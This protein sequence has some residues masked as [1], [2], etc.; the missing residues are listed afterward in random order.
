MQ[1]AAFD[2]LKDEAL[3]ALKKSIRTNGFLP[4]DR[5]IVQSYPHAE[6]TYVVV[7][8]NRRVA[9]MRWLKEDVASG[10]LEEDEPVVTDIECIPVLEIADE[11][12][13][14]RFRAKLMGIRH[15][16]GIREWGGYQRAKLV[17]ALRDE[18][19]LEAGE[20]ADQLG[21]SATEVNRRYRAYN[22]LQQM[23]EHEDYAEFA[24][25]DMYPLFH[26]A[27]SLPVVREWVGWDE[28]NWCFEDTERLEQL[29]GLFTPQED[30]NRVTTDP[31]I[32]KFSEVRELR[33][34]LPNVE[35]RRLLFDDGRTFFDA[36]RV[37]KREEI[38]EELMTE[39]ASVTQTIRNAGIVQL[40]GLEEGQVDIIR[41]LVS[42][43]EE[44]L[45]VLAKLGSA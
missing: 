17:A 12:D 45:D 28:E 41:D 43:A 3:I 13:A 30:D 38:S 34:I 8:G 35:A 20:I 33:S 21:M 26:E 7:E 18:H 2:R 44:V 42:A 40:K 39:V 32:T 24:S 25:P 23:S 9:A 31:K 37:A 1:A 11:E 16:S 14:P 15:V 27:V 4:V 19:G 22:S 6:D 36:V 29:Y 5:I 10:A